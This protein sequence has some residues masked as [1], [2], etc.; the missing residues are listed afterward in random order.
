[1]TIY[2]SCLVDNAVA[3]AT[4]SALVPKEK[5]NYNSYDNYLF[6]GRAG[7][8]LFLLCFLFFVFH[9]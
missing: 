9:L 3:T 2:V 4:N 6:G 1:M 7:D 5:Q 8:C